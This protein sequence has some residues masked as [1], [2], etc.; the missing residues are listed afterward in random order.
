MHR[1]SKIIT[2]GILTVFGIVSLS[3]VPKQIFTDDLIF[4]IATT[5]AVVKKE[6]VL[7]YKNKVFANQEI[8]D[9]KFESE[10]QKMIEEFRNNQDVLLVML[11]GPEKIENR[12]TYIVAYNEEVPEFNIEYYVVKNSNI[13]NSVIPCRTVITALKDVGH[14]VDIIYLIIVLF[15]GILLLAITTPLLVV[16]IVKYKKQLKE[17]KYE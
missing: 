13:A 8:L 12:N 6:E 7:F 14:K 9:S 5:S 15:F 16:N 11:K 10:T 4:E 1:L 17:E 2:F 3:I